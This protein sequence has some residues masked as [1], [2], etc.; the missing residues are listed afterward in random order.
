MVLYIKVYRLATMSFSQRLAFFSKKDM[1][2]EKKY[3]LLSTAE[4]KKGIL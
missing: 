4:E 1:I 3:M 2:Y